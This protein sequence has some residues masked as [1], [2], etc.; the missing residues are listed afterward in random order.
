MADDVTAPD[1]GAGLPAGDLLLVAGEGRL[2]THALVANEL[3]I[4]RAP[5][6]D[7]VVDHRALSRRHAVLRRGAQITIQ[8]LG[9]TN[10]TRIHSGLLLG[11]EPAVLGPG[12]SFHIGPLTF[13]LVG[14]RNADPSSL[15][16]GSERMPMALSPLMALKSFRV[17]MPWAPML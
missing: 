9:S 1:R 13:M 16:T 5:E 3:V 12:E 15:L 11:G 10:G 6:C 8:D 17:M 4:G 14:A 2:V 7:V